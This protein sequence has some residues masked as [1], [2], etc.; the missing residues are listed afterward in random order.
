[1]IGASGA[2]KSTLA[3]SS[4]S[5]TEIVSSNAMRAIVRDDE[6]NLDGT[7]D[8]YELVRTIVDKRLGARRLTVVDA[9]NVRARDRAQLIAIARRHGA[10]V[11]AIVLDVDGASCI[12]RNDARSNRVNSRIY[13]LRQQEA[14]RA[15]M[16]SLP[17]EGFAAVHVVAAAEGE[18]EIRRG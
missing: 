14:L 13:V 15:S 5:P 16:P 7:S 12:A 6:T 9:T 17:S 2:G 1:M 3:Q 11:V 4:F 18:I 10:P 8:A